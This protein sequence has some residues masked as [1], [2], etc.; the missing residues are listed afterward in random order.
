[1]RMEADARNAGAADFADRIAA[2]LS[3]RPAKP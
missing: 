3:A 1:V 2:F